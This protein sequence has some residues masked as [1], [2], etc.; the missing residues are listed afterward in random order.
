MSRASVWLTSFV[1]L[2]Q[3]A[4]SHAADD[5]IVD[6]S[7]G[8][9]LGEWNIDGGGNGK[10]TGKIIGLG[11]GEYRATFVAYD[12]GEQE[13]E[14]F[15][16]SLNGTAL[17]DGRIEFATQINL[18]PLGMFDYKAYIKEGELNG[19]YSNG[20]NYKGD[21]SLKRHVVKPSDVGAKPLPGAI[22]LFDG[23]HL[24]QW[25]VATGD[26]PRWRVRD[27][28]LENVP[29]EGNATFERQHLVSRESFRNGQIHMEY[30]T[31]YLPESREQARGQGGVFLRGRYE[32]QILDD[33]GFPRIKNALGE[34]ADN[35]ISGAVF[36]QYAP[37]EAA[38]LPPGEWQSLDLTILSP[39]LNAEGKIQKP[40]ML[41]VVH[42][43][44]TVQERVALERPTKG[45]PLAVGIEPAGIILEDA[46]QAV[47]YRN[48]WMVRLDQ[49][50]QP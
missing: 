14:S 1:L 47:Q 34:F 43:G 31:P 4:L 50:A 36:G 33:F 19:R 26:N 2:T 9:W 16:F 11:R 12:G 35:D 3:F 46:G 27:G 23:T 38:S 8:N 40:G 15:T 13:S 17:I 22:V 25:N 5:G 45:S 49:A 18:G 20:M 44:I 42:N 29:V 21:F 48:I 28:A 41:T 32:V 39:E 30:R 10:L 24:D 37:R 6:P 7:Q